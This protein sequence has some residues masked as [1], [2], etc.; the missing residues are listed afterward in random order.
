MQKHQRR[1]VLIALGLV[2]GGLAIAIAP[3]VQA[4]AS[5]Q[6]CAGIVIDQGSGATPASQGA[7]VAPGSSDLDLLTA[8]GDSFMENNSGLVCAINGY[9]ANGLQNCLEVSHGLYYY[10]SYWEGD[11][12]TN[13]WTYASVGPAEHTLNS[14]Q[15][16]VEGWRYQDPGFDSPNATP[17]SV[18]PAVA[19]TQACSGASSSPPGGGGTGSGGGGG[20]G[21]PTTTTTGAPSSSPATAPAG[22]ANSSAPVTRSSPSSPSTS[23]PTPSKASP[24]LAPASKSQSQSTTTS[25]TRSQPVPTRTADKQA[26]T[27]T[28][29]K[30][31][32]GGNPALP[33]VLAG[34]LIGLIGVA[35][36]FTWRRR[37]TEE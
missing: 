8:A 28:S 20:S 33:I 1:G 30:G 29:K 15:P 3:A 16:Y 25:T 6:V 14:G 27:S 24:A 31:G 5:G 2:A 32:S 18:K 37:P 21:I 4:M 10:W 9:P 19:Y 13:A 35:A 12:T 23:P 7:S 11:P 22:S 17:P 34:A 26:L 36:W